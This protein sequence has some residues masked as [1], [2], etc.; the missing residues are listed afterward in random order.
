M[1]TTGDA[2]D[3]ARVEDLRGTFRDEEARKVWNGNIDRRPALIARC[4]GVADVVEAVRFARANELLVAVRSGGHSAAGYSTCDGG[5]VIDLSRLKGIR[6]DPD[7]RTARA[8]PGVIWAEFDRETQAFGLAT[9]GGTVSNTGIAGLTLGGGEGWLQGQCGLTCDNLLSA[10]VVTAD[11]RFL[12]AS[13]EENPDLFW[14]LRGG[15]GNFG[16]VTSFEYRLHPIGPLVLGGMVIHPLA[17]AREV[18]RFY[19]EFISSL[20]DEAEAWAVMLTSPDGAPVTALLLAY[21]GPLAE[22]ERVLEPA[23][24]FGPPLADL[25]QPMPYVA[26]QTLLDDGLGPHGVQRYWKS[27]FA[28]SLSD[29]LIERAVE[30]A[31]TFTSPMSVVAFVSYFHGAATRVASDATAFALR[32]AQ[33]DVDA[34][35]QWLDPSESERHIAWARQ[36]WAGM[37]PFTTGA[38]LNHL[39][40]DDRPERIRASYGRNYERLVALKNKYDPTN[41]FRLNANVRPSGT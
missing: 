29:E 23:R 40:S 36:V 35:A 25:V 10:D 30:G 24:K 26:R 17:R 3:Q 28:T 41:L 7:G 22:G 19:R 12:R 5:I 15:G 14:G 11:G 21:N 31:E 34:V 37:E 32:E 33:W 18:L 20:P 9:T 38:Y 27:G 1:A 8:Q 2:L 39:A 16:L 4:T 6:V 13:A